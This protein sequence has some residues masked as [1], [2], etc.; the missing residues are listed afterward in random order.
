[1]E[2][3]SLN[4]RE[5]DRVVSDVLIDLRSKTMTAH[6]ANNS[7]L[8]VRLV[9][10]HL[11]DPPMNTP[12]IIDCMEGRGVA[13]TDLQHIATATKRVLDKIVEDG[14][15]TIEWSP[16]QKERYDELVNLKELVSA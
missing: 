12:N 16:L 6:I 14:E 1:M 7:L 2:N 4:T 11:T 10:M 13:R 8:E 15:T 9:V 3:R 5:F